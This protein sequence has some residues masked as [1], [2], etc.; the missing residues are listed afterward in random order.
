MAERDIV[1]SYE[2]LMRMQTAAEYISAAVFLAGFLFLVAGLANPAWVRFNRRIW[3]VP[4]TLAAWAVALGTYGSATFFTH[5]QPNGPHSFSAYMDASTAKRC[6]RKPDLK[7]CA[8]LRE[9]CARRDPTHPPCRILA[10]E[11]PSKFYT[12]TTRTN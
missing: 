11:D 5:A 4:I 8:E 12:T 3:V 7:I 2:N 10:G 1:M 6:I 9:K